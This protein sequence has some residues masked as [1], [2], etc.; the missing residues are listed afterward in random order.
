MNVSPFVTVCIHSSD[1]GSEQLLKQKWRR[2]RPN[3]E[4]EASSLDE[5]TDG[6]LDCSQEEGEKGR[7]SIHSRHTGQRKREALV[8]RSAFAFEVTLHLALT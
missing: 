8:T 6:S 1:S 4:Q 5:L 7:T 3:K 2:K